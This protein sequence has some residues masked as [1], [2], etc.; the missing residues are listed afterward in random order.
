MGYDFEVSGTIPAS[1]HDIYEAWMSGEGHSAMTGADA[2]V[3]PSVGGA[4][5]AWDGYI[6]GRTLAFGTGPA[7]RPDLADVGVRRIPHGFADRGP[8]RTGGG[9]DHRHD[10][11][12]ERSRRPA[13][14]RAR[15]LA[16]ELLRAHA[17]VFQGER[18]MTQGL[19]TAEP[20]RSHGPL[21]PEVEAN[22]TVVQNGGRDGQG[23]PREGRSGHPWPSGRICRGCIPLADRV[24]AG[25]SSWCK[26][27]ERSEHKLPRLDGWRPRRITRRS[28]SLRSRGARG[29]CRLLR[30]RLVPGSHLTGHEGVRGV[31]QLT[32]WVHGGSDVC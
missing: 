1:P 10:P 20:C 15:W 13:R 2:E 21:E 29:R 23:G 32:P 18:E 25:G 7:D 26:L 27:P 14:L 9:G 5:S 17:C 6:T 12:H 16:G 19:R 31:K 4:H 3:D 30:D 28:R 11:P 8:A 24:H 22:D